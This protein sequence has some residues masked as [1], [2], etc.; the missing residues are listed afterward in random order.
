MFEPE[1]FQFPTVPSQEMA[2]AMLLNYYHEKCGDCFVI[3][4]FAE[5][6]AAEVTDWESLH[7]VIEDVKEQ[8]KSLGDTCL[9]AVRVD[10]PNRPERQ[11]VTCSKFNLTTV[12]VRESGD[13]G[14]SA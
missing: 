14:L 2:K 1:K 11:L 10:H 13:D 12:A 3:D 4:G 6:R 5:R 8:A 7:Q 9:G